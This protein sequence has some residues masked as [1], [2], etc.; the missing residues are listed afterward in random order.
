MQ[1]LSGVRTARAVL[2]VGATSGLA[3]ALAVALLRALTPA[4]PL[5]SAPGSRAVAGPSLVL[6][7]GAA[8][9][10]A[11]VLQLALGS[12]ELRFI[13]RDYRHDDK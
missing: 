12:L 8:A 4:P 11:G 5:P 7:L 6:L 3:A 9:L 13:G 1:A 10:A 2:Q